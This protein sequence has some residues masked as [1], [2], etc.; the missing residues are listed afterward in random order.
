M[1][2]VGFVSHI[3]QAPMKY[4]DMPRPWVFL[5]GSIAMGEAEYWQEEV[6]K[7]L[8][9]CTV[10]NPRRDN[11]D[12]SWRQEISDVRFK[13][14]VEWELQA[15]SSANLTLIYF[16]PET[17]APITLLELGLQVGRGRQTLVCCP[18]GFYRRGNVE[19]TC[20]QLNVP[21]LD[22]KSELIREANDFI[23]RYNGK[24]I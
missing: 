13:E 15:L 17:F 23:R 8:D 12:S 3:V 4:N 10:L 11:W 18:V 20:K 19:I 2:E 9:K 6:T 21:F 14:Q 16:D 1:F 24:G 5:S 7:E 22:T